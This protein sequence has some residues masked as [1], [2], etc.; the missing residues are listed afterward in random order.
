MAGAGFGKRAGF[1]LD[2]ESEPNSGAAVIVYVMC[3][4]GLSEE[5]LCVL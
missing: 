4:V 1:L 5:M 3:V 2:P